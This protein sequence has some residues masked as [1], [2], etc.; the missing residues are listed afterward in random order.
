MIKWW[1]DRM[2]RATST[3]TPFHNL[4]II[5]CLLS[6]S[7][8]AQTFQWANAYGGT[9]GESLNGLVSDTNS[10]L[11]ISGTYENSINLGANT[12]TSIGQQ[13]LYLA[14]LD[15][16]GQAI[17][18][19]RAGSTE[20][21]ENAGLAMYNDALYIAGSYWDTADFGNLSISRTQGSNS[22]LYL[23]RYDSNGNAIWAKSIDG[24]G[25]KKVEDIQVDD[26]GNIYLTGYFGGTL[27]TSTP[28][29]S[30]N[31]N[32]NFFLL[33]YNE[34]GDLLWAKQTGDSGD[35]RGSS[36]DTDA[37]GNVY[38]GGRFQG[39]ISFAGEF[40]PGNGLDNDIFLLK[41]DTNGNEQ[42]IKEGGGVFEDV[43]NAIIADKDGNT[44]L[45]GYFSGVLRWG[46]VELVAQGFDD[47]L[48]L[49]KHDANGNL[50]W[51]KSVGGEG[52]AYGQSLA[53]SGTQ[54]FLG[55]HFRG[56]NNFD[57]S[58]LTAD[59]IRF[60]VFIS[61]L[62]TAGN[63]QWIRQ[64]GN[65]EFDLLECLT[66]QPN[67]GLIAGG[68]FDNNTIFDNL[69]LS[70]SGGYDAYLVAIADFPLSVFNTSFYQQINIYPNPVETHFYIHLKEAAIME[71]FD[72]QGRLVQSLRISDSDGK[73]Q[74]NIERLPTGAYFFVLNTSSEK[75]VG[76]F[77]KE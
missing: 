11:Y 12:L 77:V 50:I 34:N 53:L 76:R 31:G 3:I 15:D 2:A 17:W 41:Y 51:A 74:I 72:L 44:Y 7:L 16:L 27:F 58:T 22:A 13:D 47:N 32:T 1:N 67:T 55:G 5:L 6:T 66:I 45:T 69:S 8:H 68:N 42:W 70:S 14:Q 36:L 37:A 29:L 39:D 75:Q 19:V 24:S 25:I 20:D 33:K 23:A 21:D 59:A 64:A 10:K 38:V 63:F 9:G 62:D 40:I 73:T 61:E 71:I 60:D 65:T 52:D 26:E 48:V 30:A 49:A 4:T 18:A 56:E 54:L 46:L 57:N 35:I 43:C 28:N